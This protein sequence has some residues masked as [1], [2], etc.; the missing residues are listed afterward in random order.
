MKKFN[1]ETSCKKTSQMKCSSFC[2]KEATIFEKTIKFGCERSALAGE[3]EQGLENF[4]NCNFWDLGIKEQC[5]SC[6]LICPENKNK[7]IKD[8]EL[9]RQNL[10]GLISSLGPMIALSGKSKDD[11]DKITNNI[12][13]STLNNSNINEVLNIT[14]YAKSI[15]DGLVSGKQVDLAEFNKI[16]DHISKKY[17][18]TKK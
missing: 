12:S 2:T 7:K 9:Q 1:C 17:G 5:V 13:S 3:I 8:I 11:L 18:N 6:E 4:L 15:L 10:Q 16:K 14:N